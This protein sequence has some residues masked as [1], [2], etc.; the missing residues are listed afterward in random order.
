MRTRYET[1]WDSVGLPA[2]ARSGNLFFF[3]G[4]DFVRLDLQLRVVWKQRFG[5]FTP[6]VISPPWASPI[7]V[8]DNVCYRF[9]SITDSGLDKQEQSINI[10]DLAR[11]LEKNHF[12]RPRFAIGQSAAGDWLLIA[13]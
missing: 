9:A 2:A 1:K 6:P 10:L 13:Y 3:H 7:L 4:Q 8:H 11:E 12:T 5:D